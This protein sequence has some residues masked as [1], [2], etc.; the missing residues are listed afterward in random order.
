MSDLYIN[1][2]EKALTLNAADRQKSCD[3]V[4]G[5][6]N[7]G[8]RN[9]RWRSKLKTENESNFETL[10]DDL[11]IVMDSGAYAIPE[12]NILVETINS[13]NIDS[14]VKRGANSGKNNN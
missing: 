14:P 3:N 8:K 12:K 6:R 11:Y 2:P 1:E 9:V 10:S 7:P 4:G 5:E 13:I